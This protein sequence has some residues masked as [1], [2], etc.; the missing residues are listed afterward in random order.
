M[1]IHKLDLNDFQD[2]EYSLYAIHSE[3][4]DYRL[5]HAIN[6][7]LK[8]SLRRLKKDLDFSTSKNLFFSLFQ[9]EDPDLKSQ[10]NLIKNSCQVELESKG[11]GL[12]FKPGRKKFSKNSPFKRACCCRLFFKN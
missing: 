3:A 9:W 4:E 2:A 10:W 7:S 5:A 11:Q 8:T 6:L 12:F 1:A